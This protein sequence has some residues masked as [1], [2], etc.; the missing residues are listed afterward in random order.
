MR[1]SSIGLITLLLTLFWGGCE[2]QISGLKSEEAPNSVQRNE[3]KGDHY[4]QQF[5]L[6]GLKRGVHLDTSAF[7]IKGLVVETVPL[8]DTVGGLCLLEPGAPR[9]VRINSLH[10]GRLSGLQEELLFFHEFGHCLLNRPHN[11]TTLP[12]GEWAS[13]MYDGKAPNPYGKAMDYNSVK[14]NYYL[15]ELFIKDTPTPEWGKMNL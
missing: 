15:D 4:L 7:P 13:L 8:P 6:E 11:N 14:R 1:I 12:N 9:K 2:L 5:I 3:N 10:L